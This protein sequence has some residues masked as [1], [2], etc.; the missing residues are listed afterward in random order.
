MKPDISYHNVVNELINFA[1]EVIENYRNELKKEG[2]VAS[3]QMIDNMK[4]NLK[5]SGTSI[6]VDLEVADYFYYIENGRGPTNNGN[7]GGPTLHDKIVDWLRDKGI[8]PENERNLPTEQ[9]LDSLAWAIT[10]K[11]HQ[12][13][14][15][16][17]KKGGTHILADI[18]S[19]TV[20]KYKP[21]LD[22][23][24]AKDFG[25]YSISILKEINKMI[26]I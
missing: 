12:E 9:A 6:K 14:T 25:E 18:V 19:K 7:D 16:I 15:S 2:H 20:A 10:T 5:V 8:T 23:A 11:I 24:L 13:G 26:K 4:T 22:A 1:N 17:Y 3:G 21:L